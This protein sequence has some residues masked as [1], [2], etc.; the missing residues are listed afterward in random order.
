MDW[1]G[2]DSQTFGWFDLGEEASLTE[3]ALIWFLSSFGIFPLTLICSNCCWTSSRFAV[4][5]ARA[6]A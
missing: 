5:F 1:M 3:A 6:V 2:L 4:A